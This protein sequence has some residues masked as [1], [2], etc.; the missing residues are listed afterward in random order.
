[1]KTSSPESTRPAK[2][3][4]EAKI[5]KSLLNARKQAVKTAKLHGTSIVYLKDGKVVRERP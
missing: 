3:S 2:G 5:L 4:R 1:M